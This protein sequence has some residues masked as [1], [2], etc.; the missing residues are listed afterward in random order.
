MSIGVLGPLSH[1]GTAAAFGRR[2]RAVLTALAMF[3]GE[4]VSADR[5][6]DAVWG[7]SPPPTSHK[8]LQGCVVRLR[9]ALGADS[10]E[11]SAQGYRLAMAAEEVDSQRFE[12]M[13]T[14]GR[15]QLA[16][17]EPE[18]TAYM[19]GQALDLWRGRAFEEIES[20]DLAAVE[21]A[22]L[23]K[24]RL[25]AEELRVEACLRTGRHLA[26]LADA[27]GMVRAAPMRERRWT[28]LAL[29]QYQGGQQT[30]A[31]RTISRVKSLLADRLGLDPGPELAALEQAMLRHD[32]S[33]ISRGELPT[34]GS[35]PYPGLSPYDV[36][37]FESFFGRDDDVQACLDLLNSG[38]SLAVVG[39]SGS[40][41]SSLVRAGVAASIQRGRAGGHHHHP[42][43][44]PD[45]VAG[46]GGRRGP[47]IGSPGR[48]VRGG[49]LACA[50]RRR[51]AGVLRRARRVGRARTPG[52][53]AY[54]RTDWPRC[55]RTRFRA[56]GRAGPA[57]VGSHE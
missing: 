4:A 52:T 8:A 13:V 26:V 21:A 50:G 41:K 33:L 43:R 49:L 34:S 2:D 44:A 25:E 54:A 37:D 17:G 10:I 51:T 24:L 12:R 31:L 35:C 38:S 53:R 47:A 3:V 20:W 48:P 45:A 46:G 27:E 29:A 40:G 16:L 18:R 9:R 56:T 30:E 1:G 36:D 11:T 42:G 19:L 57:P 7:D 55:R 23:E 6:A 39:P 32:P 22:R 5:L 28:L 15:E 14:R